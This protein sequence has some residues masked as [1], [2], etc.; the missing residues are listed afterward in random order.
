MPQEVHGNAPED[1][2]PEPYDYEPPTVEERKRLTPPEALTST[3]RREML[4][5]WANQSKGEK[6]Q[7]ELETKRTTALHL[8]VEWTAVNGRVTVDTPA[9]LFGLADLMIQYI[10][11]G[12]KPTRDEA[13][14][15]MTVRQ[16]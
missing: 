13:R 15:A 16:S 4:R 8:A 6:A 7:R 1:D 2:A 9:H 11:T 10:E 3:E 14:R 12:K 5:E